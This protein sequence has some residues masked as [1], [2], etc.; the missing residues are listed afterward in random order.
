VHQSG[1]AETSSDF[2]VLFGGKECVFCRPWE[3]REA[4]IA[5]VETESRTRSGPRWKRDQLSA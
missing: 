1:S 3:E 2:W 4:N 5:L